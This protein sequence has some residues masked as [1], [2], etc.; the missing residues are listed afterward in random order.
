VNRGRGRII[1]RGNR[2]HLDFS[3]MHPEKGVCQVRDFASQFA[4]NP[5]A[6]IGRDVDALLQKHTRRQFLKQIAT[7]LLGPRTGK[8]S[9]A[10]N[11]KEHHCAA[12]HV[13]VLPASQKGCDQ[14][15][16]ADNKAVES[17]V[18]AASLSCRFV[19]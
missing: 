6:L 4:T 17:K 3:S 1:R 8:D 13:S 18:E 5:F 10:P 12:R 2:V 9:D 14:N 16:K 15:R 19:I 7:F 11:D